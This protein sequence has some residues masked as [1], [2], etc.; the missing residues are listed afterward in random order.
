MPR[1]PNTGRRN[2]MRKGGYV[3]LEAEGVVITVLVTQAMIRALL[4]P[5]SEPLW[6]ALDG[7]AGG[8]TGQLILLGFIALVAMVSGGWARTRK[9]PTT[10]QAGNSGGIHDRGTT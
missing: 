6:G 9:E 7:V 3:A 1:R 5:G 4:N 10:E 2:A 8:L